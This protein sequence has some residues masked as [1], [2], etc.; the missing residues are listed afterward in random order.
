MLEA[1][2]R[3]RHEQLPVNANAEW[4]RH[5]TESPGHLPTL[6]TTPLPGLSLL[7]PVH[8]SSLSLNIFPL[9]G[10]QRSDLNTRSTVDV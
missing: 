1:E 4:K 8:F 5:R 2:G 3:P 9:S 7:F 10:V 6:S